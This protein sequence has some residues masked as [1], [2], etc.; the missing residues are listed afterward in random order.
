MIKR[1]N[2]SGDTV[3]VL[4]TGGA[5]FIG[6]HLV[7]VLLENNCQVNVLD[8]K[9]VSD[10]KVEHLVKLGAKYFHGDITNYSD[11]TEAGAGCNHIVHLA[12]QTSV[13][14]SIQNPKLNNQVNI[15]VGKPVYSY[16]KA[17]N[18]NPNFY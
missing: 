4:V 12:A 13:P 15:E 16:E 3:K 5:G 9:Q 17:I 14:E 1:E 6:H 10:E 11:V 18:L 7:V 8:I 2:Q